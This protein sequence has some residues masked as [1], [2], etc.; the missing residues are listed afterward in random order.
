MTKRRDPGSTLKALNEL[1]QRYDGPI[2]K[3]LLDAAY[4]IDR[5][6]AAEKEKRV[7]EDCHGHIAKR[8]QA[9]SHRATRRRRAENQKLGRGNDH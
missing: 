2:P 6:T 5:C 8:R 9:R 3:H 1:H 7:K 4:A